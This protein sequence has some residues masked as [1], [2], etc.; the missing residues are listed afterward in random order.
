MILIISTLHRVIA[1]HKNK[2]K[3][4]HF[5]IKK[6]GKAEVVEVDSDGVVKKMREICP[7]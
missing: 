5:K 2:A 4:K 3:S 7:T 6:G 1:I